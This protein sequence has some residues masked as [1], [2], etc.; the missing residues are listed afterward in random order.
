MTMT[1]PCPIQL[2]AWLDGEDLLECADCATSSTT[3]SGSLGDSRLR[4]HLVA[5]PACRSMLAGVRHH[6][7]LVKR[8]L[9]ARAGPP[10]TATETA[11]AL[12]RF[13]RSV[14]TRH[15]RQAGTVPATFHPR[16]WL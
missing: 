7:D 12:A 13:R 5:C 11:I 16:E 8:L 2:R 6:A 14:V 1:C 10:P 9:A 4:E 15:D 3:S